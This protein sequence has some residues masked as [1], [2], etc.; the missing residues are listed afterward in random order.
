LNCFSTIGVHLDHSAWCEG[1]T[2]LAAALAVSLRAHLLGVFAP[3]RTEAEA[4]LARIGAQHEATLLGETFR[5]RAQRDGV[6]SS[7]CRIDYRVAHDPL[8]ELARCSDLVVLSQD[9]TGLVQRVLMRGGCPLLVAPRGEAPATVGQRI[10]IAWDGLREASRAVRDALPLLAHAQQV[11]VVALEPQEG[12][13]MSRRHLNDVRAWLRRHRIETQLHW[14]VV[15]AD[16]GDELL[17]RATRFEADLIVMGGY[18]HLPAVE[19]IFGGV[20]RKV[21]SSAPVPVLVSH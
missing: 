11:H 1:R 6:P 12:P 21:L 15:R 2:R 14:D 9:D 17:L 13:Q 19:A 5:Q 4:E 10:M 7:D 16:V 3:A 20:T 18:G 8:V